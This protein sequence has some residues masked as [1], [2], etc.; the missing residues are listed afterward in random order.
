MPQ[1]IRLISL[2]N[3]LLYDRLTMGVVL[4]VE[5]DASICTLVSDVLVEEGFSTIAT[6]DGDEALA[7]LERIRPTVILL[8][9]Y[10]P[11]VNGWGFLREMRKNPR[12]ASVPVIVCTAAP[13]ARL[14]PGVA[15]YLRKPFSLDRLIGLI[16]SVWI[17]TGE[18]AKAQ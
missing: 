5:D 12:F 8:D 17:S 15:G 18:I 4:V 1:G 13:E 3:A 2:P 14:P 9:L 11:R 7:V 6:H 16:R 10:M